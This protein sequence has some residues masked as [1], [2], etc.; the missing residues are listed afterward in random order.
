MVLPF[1]PRRFPPESHVDKPMAN[2]VDEYAAQY[3]KA[4][5]EKEQSM[6]EEGVGP[7]KN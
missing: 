7:L 4:F 3:R 1:V 6:F 5:S 2:T